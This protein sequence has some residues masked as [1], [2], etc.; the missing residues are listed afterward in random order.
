MD[1][2]SSLNINTPRLSSLDPY[3]ESTLN[4]TTYAELTVEAVHFEKLRGLIGH[5]PNAR[6]FGKG[7]RFLPKSDVEFKTVQRYLHA[8]AR[9]DIVTRYYAL[10][11]E[12]PSKVGIRGLPI[13]TAPDIIV[14]EL[15]ELD[16][17]A[18]Y[19]RPIPPQ[20]SRPGCLFYA[21]LGHMGQ[22][23]LQKLYEVNTLL[24]MPGITIEGWRG[25]EGL[26]QCHRCQ[27]FRH[28][29]VNCHRPQR[30]V[31]CGEGHIAADCTKP[32]DQGPTR[33]NC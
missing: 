29:S 8:T 6:P 10:E 30:C 33:A 5:I 32:R 11:T 14:P 27:A 12:K 2:R 19:V 15:Q 18:E 23:R 25:R 22:D 20:K 31:C 13:D 16:F 1:Q 7:I 26:P 17:P 24:N 28:S 21:R 9:R 4:S 3:A